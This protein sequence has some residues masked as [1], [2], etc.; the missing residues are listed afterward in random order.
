MT[1]RPA[2]RYGALTLLVFTAVHLL[3]SLL[4]GIFQTW[5]LQAGDQLL[6]LS[7]RWQ[8]K[9]PTSPDIIHIDLDDRSLATLP[10]SK[11]DHRLYAEVIDI[12]KAAGV[13]TVLMDMIFPQCGDLAGCTA[14]ASTVEAAGNVHFPVILATRTGAPLGGQVHFP[15]RTAWH[16]EGIEKFKALRGEMIM[17]NYIALNKAA[18]GLGHINCD[19]DRDGVYRRIPLFIVT[20]AGAV[21]S[22]ALRTLCSF[23]GVTEE[24]VRLDETGAVVL[25]GAVFASGRSADLRI[26]VDEQGR[27]RV[28]FS[29]PWHD[30]FAHYSFATLLRAGS[31]PQGRQDLT[32]ELEGS[33]AIVSDISTGGRDIGPIPLASY[34]P[35]SGLHGNFINSVLEND[36]LRETGPLVNLLLSALLV[37]CLTGGAIQFRGFR[38]GVWAATLLAALLGLLLFL[39]LEQRLL[40]MTVRPVAALGLTVPGILL[41]QFLQEQ[42]EKLAVRARL[43]HLS[44]YFAPSVMD[45]IL[46]EP[47]LLDGV[48]KKELT[49]LFSDI[50]GFTAWS[51]TR[52]AREIHR[53]LNRYFEEM[54][55]IVFAHQGTI[56]KFMGDGLLVFFGDPVAFPDHARR[57]VLAARAMQRRTGELRREW[58]GS[59]GMPIRIRIGIHTGEV[60]VGNLGSSSRMEYTVIGSNVNLAQRLEANCPP[61]GIL[62]S[63]EVRRRLG[64]EIPA[65]PAGRIQAKGFAEP[66]AVYTVE[67]G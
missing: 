23:L 35:L 44:H 34:Y 21:P 5:E 14:L 38:F 29:G 56:D 52:E 22:L 9:R 27:N 15:P 63:E 6:R 59:G 66:I 16:I 42:R 10:Y 1:E 28:H 43:A 12:L 45:K 41:L 8:G 40:F 32:D 50:A 25:S 60:V 17:S 2:I 4:P 31:S 67:S 13:R 57:A 20:P 26:P 49:V 24:R 53:T 11:N 30:S 54:A 62:I 39:F 55:A 48:D 58:E 19:P 36:P 37:L 61:G 33:L 7:Y 46:N 18:A 51:A 65:R 3:W 64:D 47:A